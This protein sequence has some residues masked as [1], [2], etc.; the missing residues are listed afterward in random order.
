MRPFTALLLALLVGCGEAGDT[1]QDQQLELLHN[2]A[3]SWTQGYTDDELLE[4]V[5]RVCTG[6][7]LFYEAE[8]GSV[9]QEDHGY[10]VGMAL[11]SEC[12]RS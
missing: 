2:E 6:D 4:F 11:S 8:Q 12:D 9:S 5:G 10:L 7:T 3:P 1:R